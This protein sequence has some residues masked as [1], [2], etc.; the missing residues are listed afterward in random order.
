MNFLII[1]YSIRRTTIIKKLRILVI[2][3]NKEPYQL[4]IE[5]KLKNLQA[6]VG[7]CIDIIQLE[8]NVDLICNDEGKLERLPL[9]RLISYDIISGTFLIT[10]QHNGETIS[11]SRKQIRKYKKIFRLSNHQK[12]IEYLMYNI[13]NNRLWCDVE[14]Y[15][16]E[17]G[18]KLNMKRSKDKKP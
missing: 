8:H 18:I 4:R 6:L 12:Y 3:P 5:H 7:G 2:E 10:G 17:K 1:Y 13:K 14:K 11:L 9:N 16:V 15:G